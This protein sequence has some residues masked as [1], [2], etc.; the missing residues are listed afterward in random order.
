MSDMLTS[1]GELRMKLPTIKLLPVAGAFVLTVLAGQAGAQQAAAKP[2][3][4]AL[5]EITVTGIRKSVQTAQA[6]K[7]EATSVIESV[8]LE[9]LGKFTDPSLNDAI[10]RVPGVQIERNDRG[11]LGGQVSIRGLGGSFVST[12]FN[13]R[14]A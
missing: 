9:E 1:L 12:T 13:G 14:P 7:R 8:T 10:S 5:E 6:N 11:T 3:A 4:D 2:S